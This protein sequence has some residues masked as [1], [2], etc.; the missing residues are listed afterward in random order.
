MRLF[1]RDQTLGRLAEVALAHSHETKELYD[2][3]LVDE[4]Q[5]FSPA[6][7]QLCLSLLKSPK[8]LVYAYDELQSLSGASL[9]SPEEM[10]GNIKAGDSPVWG[11]DSETGGPRHDI[12]LQRCYRNSRPVLVTAHALGFGIYR[13]PTTQSETGLIQMFD[14]PKLWTDVGYE[15]VGIKIREGEQVILKRT[16][17]TSPPF[18]EN[19]SAVEELI[20]FHR[21]EN[22]EEQAS[23]LVTA[24]LKNLR[25]DE[26]RHDDIMVVNP[27][28]LS[29]RTKVGLI[30]RRLQEKGIHSHLA[31]VDT[32]ADTFYRQDAESITLTGIHRAK[33]NEAGMVYVINAQDCNP[34]AMNLASIRNQLFTAIT[35]SSSWIRVL[36]VGNR[37][38]SL[39][40]EFNKLKQADFTLA[41]QYPTASQRATLKIVHRDITNSEWQSA[42]ERQLEIQELLT[43]WE[44]GKMKAEDA[45]TKIKD[46]W[47]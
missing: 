47:G 29:T 23:W 22:E 10:F 20:Q 11:V 34:P 43:D 45:M 14:N 28:P 36:G 42:G 35:R 44:A 15:A 37:M 41:F 17:E 5:D 7:L 31:G 24:I 33:G 27:D 25:E 2:V 13:E 30:R 26:L 1:G 38:D 32:D 8:R 3:I 19:H 40:E 9:P 39:K 12:I 18:L 21:F 4:A 46:L 16:E 6:F